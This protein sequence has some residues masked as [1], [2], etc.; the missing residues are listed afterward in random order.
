M[1]KEPGDC[2]TFFT[3]HGPKKHKS[4][5]KA[6]QET[7]ASIHLE[8]CL[9]YFVLNFFFG[10]KLERFHHPSYWQ[11]YGTTHIDVQTFTFTL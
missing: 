10:Q 11:T 6:D 7:N 8:R 3:Q 2:S 4:K 5:K 1:T 9:H